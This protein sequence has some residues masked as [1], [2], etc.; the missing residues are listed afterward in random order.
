LKDND[1]KIVKDDSIADIVKLI[2]T[3]RENAY[4]K[5]NEELVTMYYEIGKYLSEKV[6]SEKWGSKVIDNIA[7]E[8]NNKYPTLKGFNRR[9]LYRMMQFYDT[10]KNN[11]IVSTLLSQISWSNNIAILSGTKTMEEKEFYIR[12]CIKNNYSARELNR[13]LSSGYFYRYMLSKDNNALESTAKTIDEDDIPTTRIL[14]Q[15]SLE[16]LDLP[17]NY[18]EK[19]LQ[20][21]IVDNLKDFILEIG[22]D[23]SFIGKEYRVQVGNHDYYI[24]LLFYNRYLKCLVAFEL[25]VDEF[26]PEFVSKMNFY[27]EALDRQEKRIDENPSI[28]VILCSEKDQAV[29]EYAMSRNTSPLLVSEYSTKLIDKNIL[30]NKVVEIRKMLDNTEN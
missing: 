9:G 3:H 17:N 8:I 22:K 11:E 26:K 1:V 12:M 24:D 2:E 21:A 28:G 27:L 23:F 20:S 29:V 14:D 6:A 19:D 15:Y 7:R 18:K 30:E 16:F 5:V 4:R 10:Y 25:K 13:Q